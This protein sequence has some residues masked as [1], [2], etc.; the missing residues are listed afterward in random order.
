MSKITKTIA[1]LGVVAG[2]GVAALPLASYAADPVSETINVTATVGSTISLDVTENAI[3]LSPIGGGVIATD[4]TDATVSTNALGGYKL[5]AEKVSDG[6][7]TSGDYTI[8]TGVPTDNGETSYWGIKGG[9]QAEYAGLGST[10]TLKS[11]SA[12][13]NSEV[14]TITV[15][16]NAAADQQTGAYTGSFTLTATANN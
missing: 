5:T 1:A 2:L 7:L 15:G 3:A 11:T 10:V 16:V 14:T 9:S 6:N 13:A 4:T 8:A 12:V